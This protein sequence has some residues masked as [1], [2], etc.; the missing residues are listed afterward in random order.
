[1]AHPGWSGHGTPIG[2]WATSSLNGGPGSSLVLTPL[3][4]CSLS[5]ST[6]PSCSMYTLSKWGGGGGG[7]E[8]V[9]RK[10]GG[11]GRHT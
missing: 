1:M 5:M 10:V 6:S 3:R 8:Y 11:D 2:R 9:S 4:R 7:S